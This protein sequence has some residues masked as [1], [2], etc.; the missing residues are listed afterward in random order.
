M[1]GFSKK[2]KIAKIAA[3]NGIIF[4]PLLTINGHIV[5]EFGPYLRVHA[6]NQLSSF[7]NFVSV[8]EV[9]K[10]VIV[11]INKDLQQPVMH[12]ENALS[13]SKQTAISNAHNL[14]GILKAIL[15]YQD[16]VRKL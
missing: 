6:A 13:V 2:E 4:E 14:E 5:S 10:Q 1:F 8:E 11:E 15:S 12:E 16:E 7:S 9:A 3:N